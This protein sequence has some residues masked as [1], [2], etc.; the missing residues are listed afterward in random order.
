VRVTGPRAEGEAPAL[1]LNDVRGGLVDCG[2]APD[3]AGT[4]LRVSGAST[5]RVT[6]AG[7]ATWSPEGID[8]AHEVDPT[9][10]VYAT[11]LGFAAQDSGTD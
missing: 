4:F 6:L 9:A 10:V 1:W 3:G 5:E 2:I 8:R 7:H 11:R